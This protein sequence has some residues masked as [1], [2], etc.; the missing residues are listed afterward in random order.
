MAS[1]VH[2]ENLAGTEMGTNVFNLGVNKETLVQMQTEVNWCC[3]GCVFTTIDD[4][5]TNRSSFGM[6]WGA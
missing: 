4:T 3:R 1:F 2:E 5:V 6:L